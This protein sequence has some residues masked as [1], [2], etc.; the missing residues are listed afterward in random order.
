MLAVLCTQHRCSRVAGNTSAR[1]AQNP[2]APSPTATAGAVMPRFF[3]SRSTS[4]HESVDSRYPSAHARSS[5]VPSAFTPMSTRQHKRSSSRR[6]RKCTPSAHT[7]TYSVSVRSRDSKAWYSSS[8]VATRRVID[9]ADS[10]ASPL[11]NSSS[12]GAKSPV[13]RPRRYRTGSTSATLGERR[14]YLGRMYDENRRPSLR[15]WTRG[16]SIFNPPAAVT[17]VR[18]LALPLRTTNRRP[19]SSTSCW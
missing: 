7:Y 18:S 14:A 9:D 3:R 19:S 17:N 5:L 11:K 16:A 6:I 13:D 12:A 4:A 10:P 2:R 1:A 8:H 15:S